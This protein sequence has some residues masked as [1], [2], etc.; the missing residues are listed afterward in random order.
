MRFGVAFGSCSVRSRQGAGRAGEWIAFFPPGHMHRASLTLTPG[1][2]FSAPS[3]SE[4]MR[5]LTSYY[6]SGCGPPP[7]RQDAGDSTSDHTLLFFC[8][9]NAVAFTHGFE[10]RATALRN[11]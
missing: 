7:P 6:E 2:R 11:E 1:M 3:N 8:R 5:C 10:S 9:E 4:S